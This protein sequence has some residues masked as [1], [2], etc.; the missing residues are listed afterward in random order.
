MSSIALSDF[1]VYC[2]VCTSCLADDPDGCPEC[3]SPR[4]S[5]GWEDLQTASYAYLGRE[6]DGRYVVDRFVGA[7]TTGDVYRGTGTRIQRPFALKVVDTQR[8]GRKELEDEMVRRLELEVEA[9]SRLRNPHVINVY[10]SFKV[11]DHVFVIVMD[12]V[13]GV[14]LQERLDRT[15]R[16]EFEEAIEIVRQAANG[17][18]EAHQRGIIHRDMKPE[19]IMVEQMPASGVFARIL[20]FG[21]A[22]MVDSVR[23]TSGF[24]GTPLYASP[25][26]C[27]SNGEIDARSDVYSLGCVL[28]HCL[29]GRPPYQSERSLAVMEAHIEAEVPSIFDLISREQA[30]ESLDTLVRRM[31]A[32]NAQDRP[33]DCGEVVRALD[34]LGLNTRSSISEAERQAVPVGAE[35][36]ETEAPSSSTLDGLDAGEIGAPPMARQRVVHLVA[37]LELPERIKTAAKSITASAL[38]PGGDYAVI[39]DR[40]EQVHLVGLKTDLQTMSFGGAEGMNTAVAISP[41]RGE[42]YAGGFACKVLRWNLDLTVGLPR[43]VVDVGDR[44]FSLDI[45]EQG[46]RLAI[47]TER[48][49]A[50][51][52]DS[53]TERTIEVH[54][55]SSPIS[56]VR[57]VPKTGQLFVAC[58]EGQ[59]KTL[60]IASRKELRVLEPLS[61]AP[62]ASTC[63]LHGDIAAV[64]EESGE[65][66]VVS[67]TDPSAFLRIEASFANLKALSFGNDG[68]LNG[69]G[70]SADRLQLW[71]IRH[72]HVVQHLAEKSSVVS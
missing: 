26:Q 69:L 71:L 44:I 58:W 20:D 48:G 27:T 8:Y 4:P 13:E 40:E 35:P 24:R 36:T 6:L 72:E 29:T 12:F 37:S 33:Q 53:R 14:T 52:Y 66:R 41:S 51:L 57:F 54:Q 68:N 59:M 31:L 18:H 7:G 42:V 43:R 22:Y 3:L 16:L 65:L 56:A 38:G 64:V 9:M 10:E 21:I 60:D 1:E 25:E 50:L 5:A 47:G 61:S 2:P 67:L 46:T 19:N 15:G 30:P 28:F 11:R 39:A 45:D 23:Q 17:L 32:K 70:I 34:A 49:R 55:A 62:I 63:G